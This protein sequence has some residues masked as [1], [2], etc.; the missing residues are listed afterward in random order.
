VVTNIEQM[1]MTRATG[2][3]QSRMESFGEQAAKFYAARN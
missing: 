3:N 1:E 2:E